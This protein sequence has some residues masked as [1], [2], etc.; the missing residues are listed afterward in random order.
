[1]P[2]LDEL[3]TLKAIPLFATMDREQLAGLRA[4]MEPNH[5]APGQ[6]IIRD[7]EEGKYFYVILS[8]HVQYLSTDATGATLV[9]DEAGPGGFFGELSMLTGEKRLVRV[10]AKEA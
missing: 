5:F 2:E 8:G 7:G 10:Q 9:L 6:V 3:E 1:M 4:I